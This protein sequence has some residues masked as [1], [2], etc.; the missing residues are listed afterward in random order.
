MESAGSSS[1]GWPGVRRPETKD[2]FLKCQVTAKS[3]YIT[4]PDL[5]VVETREPKRKG[6]PLEDF[7]DKVGE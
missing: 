2:Y 5:T 3:W 4:N 6:R 1:D 7:L